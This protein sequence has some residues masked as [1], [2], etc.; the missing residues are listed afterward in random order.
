MDKEFDDELGSLVEQLQENNKAGRYVR[1][2][3]DP[4]KKEDLER[5][6]VEK[7]GALVEESLDMMR[8]V[9]D[10]IISAP[11]NKDVEAL[12]GLISAT[13]SAIETLNKIIVTDK[14]SDNAIKL[15]QIEGENRRVALEEETQQK[16]L[17][18]REEVLKEI[19][20][21]SEEKIAN[22]ID[23]KEID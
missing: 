1:D 9:K 6:V 22:A 8:V 11:E 17:L 13:S 15:K 23:I 5:F 2:E 18:S 19:T 14:R 20:R 7:A 4:L 21:R 10:Y 16:I 12:A 3:K